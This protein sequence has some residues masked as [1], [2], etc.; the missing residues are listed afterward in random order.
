MA[1]CSMLFSRS[2]PKPADA[3]IAWKH[4]DHAVGVE[5]FDR[6]HQVLFGLVAQVQ[7]AL[8]RRDRAEAQQVLERLLLET[9]THFDHEEC[10]MEEA[11]CP[12]LPAHAAE[13]ADLLVHLKDLIRQFQGGTLS[14]L[15]MPAFLRTWLVPHIQRADKTYGPVLR[16][17]G[18]R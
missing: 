4:L 15:A 7:A 3:P 9:R 18:V 1:W 17:A 6:E 8:A 5:P 2:K 16:R 10:A 11:A 14:M 13:H 12:D